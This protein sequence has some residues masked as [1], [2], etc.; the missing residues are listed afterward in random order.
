MQRKGIRGSMPIISLSRSFRS[1]FDL[2]Q[3]GAQ[4][5]A[6][7]LLYLRP[8]SGYRNGRRRRRSGFRLQKMRA[9]CIIRRSRQ[10]R[11][12]RRGLRCVLPPAEGYRGKYR[13]EKENHAGCAAAKMR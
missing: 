9:G 5:I 3:H 10:R 7:L 13:R 4:R 12:R 11:A 1:D 2:L 6:R 8:V